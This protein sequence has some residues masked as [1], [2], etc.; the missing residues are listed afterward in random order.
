[1]KLDPPYP[2][3]A[4]DIV[5]HY[6]SRETALEKIL[7]TKK[8]RIGSLGNTN[9]PRETKE[10]G[11][12][13]VGSGVN[14]NNK[15]DFKRFIDL[16]S[17]YEQVANSIRKEEWWALCT[18]QDDEDLVIPK[19][20]DPDF[21]HFKWGHSRGRMWAQYADCHKGVCLVIDRELLHNAIVSAVGNDLIFC[22]S[23]KYV[24]EMN[25]VG[26]N[27]KPCAFQFSLNI[28]SCDDV[29]SIVRDHIQKYHERFFLEKSLEWSSEVEF[30][31][32]INGVSGPYHIDI[33]KALRAVIVGV[34]FPVVYGPSLWRLCD[35]LGV[36][37]ERMFWINRIPTKQAWTAK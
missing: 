13:I 12:P 32:L 6:T 25:I 21:T 18:T 17:Q 11:F 8:L 24:N 5:Y 2:M 20:K 35:D 14:S 15:G 3:T 33:S 36:K 7:P 10:W 19:A 23:V 4:P 37:V 28:N 22:G 27:Y 34:D 31:W 30:R 9:D 16:S 1:M 29:D 26:F